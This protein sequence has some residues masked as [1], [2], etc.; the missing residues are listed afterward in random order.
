M[1]LAIDQI[2]RLAPS[3]SPDIEPV[4]SSANTTSILGRT[5]GTVTVWGVVGGV[6]VTMSVG[7]RTLGGV[8][9][10]GIADAAQAARQS[11]PVSSKYVMRIRFLSIAAPPCS[12]S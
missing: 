12:A 11:V 1:K 7:G 9:R 3:M 6:W 4:V 10:R 5:L 2:L 8:E